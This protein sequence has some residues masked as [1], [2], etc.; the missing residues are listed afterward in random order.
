MVGQLNSPLILA[1]ASPR[2]LELL[3]QVGICPENVHR[4]NIDET[5]NRGEA[6]A[7][8][9]ARL[10]SEKAVA[11]AES[12]PNSFV[13][14]ADTLVCLGRRVIGKASD[15]ESA[16]R[17]LKLLS[18]R[19]HQVCG[20]ICVIDPKGTIRT[21]VVKTI[22]SFKRLSETEITHYLLSEEWRDKA[23]SYA[24]QGRAASFVKYIRGSYSNIVGLSLYDTLNLLNGIG[25]RS[26]E[27]DRLCL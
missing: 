15:K 22:V 5:P 4:S 9:A 24:I 6:P 17:H 16:F 26:G 27:K 8:L 7:T 19:R 3:R 12:F 25:Y 18:G 10:A 1:S 2:R 11:G 14:G 13:V 21:R 23:G 20:G